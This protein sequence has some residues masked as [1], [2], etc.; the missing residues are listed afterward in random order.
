MIHQESDS[1]LDELIITDSRLEAKKKTR[2]VF[3]ILLLISLFVFLIWYLVIRE[4]GLFAPSGKIVTKNKIIA[5][6]S[7]EKIIIPP[8]NKVDSEEGQTEVTEDGENIIDGAGTDNNILQ[9]GLEK[10]NGK[11]DE[12]ISK[13]N[14]KKNIED[15]N[16]NIEDENKLLLEEEQAKEKKRL[17]KIEADKRRKKAAAD[18]KK[19]EEEDL[20]IK[21]EEEEKERKAEEERLRKAKEE[22][23]KKALELKKKQEE[24]E[25]NRIKPGQL[26]SLIEVDVKPVSVSTPPPK[27]SRSQKLRQTVMVMALIDHNGNVEKVRMIRKSRSKKIDTAIIQTILKWKYK[28]AEKDGVKVRVWKTINL[29]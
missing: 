18:K 14:T 9:K 2:P 19:K 15:E 1:D 4:N 27:L 3:K 24:A 17:Q 28:P 22:E 23:D 29:Q 8:I 10:G 6:N 16:K 25:K 12:Q 21:T 5:D 13:D 7:P 11:S 20:R 26:I